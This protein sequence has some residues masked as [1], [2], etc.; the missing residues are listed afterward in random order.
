[1][2]IRN[3]FSLLSLTSQ[4]LSPWTS[5]P[6]TDRRVSAPHDFFY[7]FYLFLCFRL[8]SPPIQFVVTSGS[9]CT[10]RLVLRSGS[11]ITLMV[12][13]L[14]S[15]FSKEMQCRFV[16]G[17]WILGLKAES[18]SSLSLSRTWSW[19]S[20]LGFDGIYVR[21]VSV[22]ILQFSRRWC[23]ASSIWIHGPLTMVVCSYQRCIEGLIRS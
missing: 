7:P 18:I 3:R 16:G 11:D 14:L 10:R 13:N 21:F 4:I 9:G 19:C 22:E 5:S 6:K 8:A 20:S 23:M 17:S 2:L 1:M 15:S 12:V